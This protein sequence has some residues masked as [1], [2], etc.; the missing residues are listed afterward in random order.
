M[1]LRQI[2]TV[3]DEVL[4]KE[5]KL[6]TAFDDRLHTLLDDMKE[7]MCYGD[8]GIGLA[9]P[10]VGV[11]RR[12][13]IVDIHDERG[14]MEFINP[15]ITSMQGEVIS[16]EGCLSVPN[17]EGKVRRP[18]KLVVRAQNRSGEFFELEAEGILAIC[19]A[20]END[21]LDGILYIDKL[22]E[23]QEEC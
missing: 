1:A 8:R 22:I 11:L 16:C 2:V 14:L 13:F 7:T 6:V 3:G 18:E 9:A 15:E 4:R 12:V 17:R 5:A 20:H 23:E 19:V 10:Q 21:H